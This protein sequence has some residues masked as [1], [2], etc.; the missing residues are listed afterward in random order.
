[1]KLNNSGWGLLVFLLFLFILFMVIVIVAG[2]I[3]S[4]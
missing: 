2:R 3:S 1:M 4:I